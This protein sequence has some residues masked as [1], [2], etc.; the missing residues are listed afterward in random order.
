MSGAVLLEQ[1][2]K[3]LRAAVEHLQKKK[4]QSRAQLQQGGVLQV[5]EAQNLILGRNE[6]IWEEAAQHDQQVHRRAP[7][8]YSGCYI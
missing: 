8:T 6:A 3:E 4:K 7:P 2:N 5:Q 1:E